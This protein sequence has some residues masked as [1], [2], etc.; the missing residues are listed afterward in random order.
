MA[1]EDPQTF[2]GVEGRIVAIGTKP[3]GVAARGIDGSGR[4]SVVGASARGVVLAW[5]A[6]C[7]RVLAMNA[8]A[9]IA[10]ATTV[11]GGVRYPSVATRS[12]IR[13]VHS[14]RS[15]SPLSSVAIAHICLNVT[16]C[17][18]SVVG[19]PVVGILASVGEENRAPFFGAW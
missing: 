1:F 7:L 6:T 4:G 9:S 8:T 19:R 15:S 12:L 16:S 10:L 17:R 11:V 5:F 2:A 13:A 3:V 14:A 18:G